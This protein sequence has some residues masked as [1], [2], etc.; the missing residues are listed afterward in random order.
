M[1]EKQSRG[2]IGE[3]KRERKPEVLR[4]VFHDR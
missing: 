3:F 1:G 2:D 4:V